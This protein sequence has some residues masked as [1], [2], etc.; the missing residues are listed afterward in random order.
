MQPMSSG[1]L[2]RRW[3]GSP[4]LTQTDTKAVSQIPPESLSA[5]LLNPEGDT[6]LTDPIVGGQPSP[7]VPLFLIPDT[8]TARSPAKGKKKPSKKKTTATAPAWTAESSPTAAQRSVQPVE[9]EAQKLKRKGDEEIR[10]FWICCC[11]EEA[12]MRTKRLLKNPPPEGPLIV[13]N[14]EGVIGTC[15]PGDN[16]A[17]HADDYFYDD[18]VSYHDYP[19]GDDDGG[20][21]DG[22]EEG[23][24]WKGSGG[25]YEAPAPL[26]SRR[27]SQPTARPPSALKMTSAA[28]SDLVSSSVSSG[29]FFSFSLNSSRSTQQQKQQMNPTQ[30]QQTQK[31]R[32]K[33]GA[34]TFSMEGQLKVSK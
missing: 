2:Q 13:D 19:D 23:D 20:M 7:P 16:P 30:L 1:N 28:S 26:P 33:S 10:T 25:G 4:P 34:G 12:H 18:G 17:P 24:S 14:E 9:I 22:F 27:A 31:Q 21:D 3:T 6:W 8:W 15:D 5:A 32:P 29:S 11:P